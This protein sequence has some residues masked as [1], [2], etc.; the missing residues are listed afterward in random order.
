[1]T[2]EIED[3]LLLKTTEQI[4]YFRPTNPK[5]IFQSSE[6]DKQGSCFAAW[7][8]IQIPLFLTILKSRTLTLKIP[9]LEVWGTM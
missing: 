5:L 2:L 9:Q 8:P 1:M 3:I 4:I 6:Q 7:S